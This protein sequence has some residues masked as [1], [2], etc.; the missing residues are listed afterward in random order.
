MK[1]PGKYVTLTTEGVIPH[2][3]VMLESGHI[4]AAPVRIR[5]IH[6]KQ[7]RQKAVPERDAD[8]RL[9]FALPGGQILA[10]PTLKLEA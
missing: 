10:A 7:G 2:Q 6:D 5:L 9:L 3:E 1:S 4:V 8:G